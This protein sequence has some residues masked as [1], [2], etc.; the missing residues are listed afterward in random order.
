MARTALV[1][2]GSGPTGPHIVEGLRER[3][4]RVSVLNRGVHPY[5]FP[6]DVERLVGDPHFAEPLEAALNGR[7][8]DVTV[9]TYGRLR[10]T[11]QVMKGRTGH[12]IAVGG[13]V[14]YRGFVDPRENF[15]T[16]MLVPVP[17]HAPLA[18]E[19]DHEF[20][21]QVARAE[22]ALFDAQPGAT[23]F[24]YPY[25]YGPRQVTPREWSLVR[26]VL[27]GRRAIVVMHGGMTLF[28]HIY[29]E[30]AAHALLLAVD[31]PEVAAGKAYNCADDQQVDQRQLIEI[32]TRALGVGMELI[33][34]PEVE[35]AQRALI[36]PV[37]YHFLGDV[38]AIRT[39]LGYRDLVPAPE[40]IAR[41]VLWYRDNPLEYGGE[42]EQRR[43]D[44]FD[45]EAEDKLIAIWR[46]YVAAVEAV[47]FRALH[48]NYA[49]HPYAHP[50][51][52]RQGRDEKGR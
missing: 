8:F 14:A 28:S 52:H 36:Q 7:N 24:R 40:A 22:A 38:T 16:G 23:L 34:I 25:V 6:D 43:K 19:G 32:G 46:D 12:F 35:Q 39:D 18:G 2:G 4:Y 44:V 15:P 26:R 49:H 3:G 50:K 33:S 27:D 29:S 10:V 20:E 17:E 42:Y 47:E 9:A 51:A 37:P 21:R 41:T 11:S 45:Y 31:R 13:T 48:E 30:N 5:P 1:I